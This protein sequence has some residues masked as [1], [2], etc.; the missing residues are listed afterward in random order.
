MVKYILLLILILIVLS[1]AAFALWCYHK[2]KQGI[3]PFCVIKQHMNK[4]RLTMNV[5]KKYYDGGD[6]LTPPMGWS[7]WNT[8]RNHID[9]NLIFETAEALK[10]TGLADAGYKYVNLDD[11]WHSSL[12]D[13]NGRLQGDLMRFPSGIKQLVQK[14]NSLGLKV[15]LYTSNGEYTCEDLPASLGFEKRDAETFADWG[16]EYFKYDFCHNKTIPSVAPL[17]ERIELKTNS[18]VINLTADKAKL[19]GLAR[20]SEDSKLETGKYI[21]FLGHGKGR[22]S[23]EFNCGGNDESCALTLVIKKSGKYDKYI[24]IAL[25]DNYYEMLIPETD[26]WSPSCRYQVKVS[27]K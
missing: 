24:V 3:C 23:F 12:R 1:A 14:V 17:V 27:V 7:S 6:A 22:A 11:C 2:K 16:I 10:A 8:F 5:P 20:I 21:G 19:S 26:A 25:N 18:G 15:G 9:E 4:S 13:E